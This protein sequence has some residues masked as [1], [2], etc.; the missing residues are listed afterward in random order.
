MLSFWLGVAFSGICCMEIEMKWLLLVLLAV[1]GVAAA[2]SNTQD[3][4]ANSNRGEYCTVLSKIV[5]DA[6]GYRNSGLRP[7]LAYKFISKAKDYNTL[8][9]IGLTD[10]KV[11]NAINMAYFNDGLQGTTSMQAYDAVYGT[12]MGTLKPWEPLR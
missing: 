2:Q 5:Y 3:S 6:V 1:C 12:C 9:E 10:D 7:Q 4:D 8:P 11:K